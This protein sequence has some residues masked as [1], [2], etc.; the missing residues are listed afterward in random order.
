M[1]VVKA[2]KLG[3]NPFS[4]MAIKS[5]WFITLPASFKELEIFSALIICSVID[6]FQSSK[7]C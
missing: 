4:T 6:G 1:T 5:L 7:R 2:L 3:G